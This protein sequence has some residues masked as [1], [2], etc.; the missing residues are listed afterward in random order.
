MAQLVAKRYAGAL[1]EIAF[2]NNKYLEIK[3]E[4]QFIFKCLEDHPQLFQ[5]LKT[6]LVHTMDKKETIKN[7]FKG[8]I[9]QEL[10]NFLFILLDKGRERYFQDIVREYNRLS[11]VAKNM[12]EAVVFTAIPMEQEDLQRLQVKLSMSSGKNIQLKNEVDPSIIGGILIKIGDKVIDNT[13]K[14]RLAHMQEELTQ[15]II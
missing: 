12:I 4:L 5:L 10:L 7:I 1:F 14:N 15:I 3:E 11:D 8:K 9:S 2:E 13:I 6:P